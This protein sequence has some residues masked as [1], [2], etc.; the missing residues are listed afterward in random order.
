MPYTVDAATQTI[1]IRLTIHEKDQLLQDSLENDNFPISLQFGEGH[2]VGGV[3]GWGN[4]WYVGVL[5][6]APGKE[7][8]LIYLHDQNM[9]TAQERQ[10]ISNEQPENVHDAGQQDDEEHDDARSPTPTIG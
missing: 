3:T 6:N 9:I 5:N 10:A 8:L 4:H 1:V 2:R 7:A